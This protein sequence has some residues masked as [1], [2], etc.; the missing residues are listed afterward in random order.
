MIQIIINDI[1]NKVRATLLTGLSLVNSEIAAT[2]TVLQAFGKLQ[3]Q[4]TALSN[5]LSNYVT[6]SSLAT[7]LLG[8][9]T[10]SQLADKQD[11]RIVVSSN[12]TAVNDGAYTLVANATFTDPSPVEGKGFSVLIRNG[13]ATIGGTGYSTSG[14]TVWRVFHSGA[15]ANYVNQLVLGFTPEDVANKATTFATINNT[16][17][18]S[19]QAA[20]NQ[21]NLKAGENLYLTAGNATTSSNVASNIT[22]LTASLEA[23]TVYR[24]SGFLALGC[25]NTGGMFFGFATL[26]GATLSVRFLGTTGATSVVRPL[27]VTTGSLTG[28]AIA[29]Q[30][31]TTNFAFF[32]GYIE[33]TTAGTLQ[34][35]FASAVNTQTSTVF[36]KESY[37]HLIKE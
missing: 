5:S 12:T 30:N 3:A 31:A 18:P 27:V 4:I 14:V 34:M 2:D 11:K 20:N 33:T 6:N 24:I 10:T 25:N 17:Y 28:T 26:A 21:I 13:T 19:V 1:A 9:A 35:Q 22:G 23:N 8:Y 15:W 29:T 7:T 37:L 32:S 36:E 16:L